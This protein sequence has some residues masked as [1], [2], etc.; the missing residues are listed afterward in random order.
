MYVCM[1][2]G[3]YGIKSQNGRKR[4][5]RVAEIINKNS[6]DACIGDL[7]SLSIVD[8]ISMND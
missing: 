8:N 7:V 4:S 5:R 3:K 2:T 1:Y 6:L